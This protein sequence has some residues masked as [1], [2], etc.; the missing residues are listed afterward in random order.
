MQTVGNRTVRNDTRFAGVSVE[1]TASEQTS[2]TSAMS[3]RHE[4][5]TRGCR[6]RRSSRNSC[7]SWHSGRVPTL[8]SQTDDLARTLRRSHCGSEVRIGDWKRPEASARRTVGHMYT[9]TV[10]LRSFTFVLALLLTTTPLL[11]VVCQMGCDPP[12]ATSS[13]CHKSAASPAG[14]TVR[15]AQHSC[16]HDHTSG[17]LALLASTNERESIGRVIA[18]PGPTLAHA[19]VTDARVAI[20]SMHG[21]PGLS[22]R[23]SSFRITVLRI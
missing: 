9:R 10:K 18:I 20:L 15:G 11:G 19:S 5:T 17:R 8:R 14:P 13:E 3:S 12:P 2:F 4:T 23:T 21:S 22:G 16:D 1:T 6:R 7:E